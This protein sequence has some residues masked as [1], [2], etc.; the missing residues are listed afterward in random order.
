MIDYTEL[1]GVFKKQ[2]ELYTIAIREAKDRKKW[3]S[4]LKEFER[5]E[6]GKTNFEEFL[7]MPAL[8]VMAYEF[9]ELKTFYQYF[10]TVRNM[11]CNFSDIQII[12]DG[13][14]KAVTMGIIS[15]ADISIDLKKTLQLICYRYKNIVCK[16]IETILNKDDLD[17]LIQDFNRSYDTVNMLD[18]KFS[19][20]RI[21]AAISREEY[22]IIYDLAH[23]KIENSWNILVSII[24]T[25]LNGN[26][27]DD[28]YD[29]VLENDEPVIES[30]EE[31]NPTLTL[32]SIEKKLK[33]IIAEFK[34]IIVVIYAKYDSAD[35]ANIEVSIIRGYIN[36]ITNNSFTLIDKVRKNGGRDEQSLDLLNT[37][38]DG[39]RKIIENY[40]NILSD[41][42]TNEE[43]KELVS[44]LVFCINGDINLSNNDFQKEYLGVIK[45]L[46]SISIDALFR[47]SG[48]NGLSR[49]KMYTDSNKEKD[50]AQDLKSKHG[51]LNFVPYRACSRANCRTGII[52]FEPSEPVKEFLMRKY[53]ISK[54]GAV[55]GIFEII[56][57]NGADHS[58]YS[59]L[60]NYVINNVNSII[61]LAS[62][63]RSNEPD[64]MQL[65]DIID[66]MLTV[67][68]EKQ[69]YAKKML[70]GGQK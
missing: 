16:K 29:I 63:F 27:S 65:E 59:I 57:V 37:Q 67:K 10:L 33:K 70:S 32:D 36:T 11:K 3:Q 53:N 8:K 38:I 14:N 49:L 31:D 55:F 21:L 62:L 56:S 35:S 25:M 45:T 64:L 46:E 6:L 48:I 23:D 7:K 54:Q 60:R 4:K 2:K 30:I 28:E 66:K 22:K 40:Y 20:D 13:I 61:T 39:Y 51:E 58:E 34:K 15:R 26:Y 17:E 69:E 5:Q 42:D 47:R 44:N 68:K 18:S 41:L 19:N 12:K 43:N 1:K 50:L 52:K 24:K 9:G